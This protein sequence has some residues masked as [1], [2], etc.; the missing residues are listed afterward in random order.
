MTGEWGAAGFEATS[1]DKSF[2]H[3]PLT[4]TIEGM[5]TFFFVAKNQ[6][7]MSSDPCFNFINK[8]SL[9]AE[10]YCD[11]KKTQEIYR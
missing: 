3:Y 6:G 5:L 11:N 9:I 4:R 2:S 1:Y 10:E 7:H 8:F